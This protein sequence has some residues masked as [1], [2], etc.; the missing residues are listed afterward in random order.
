MKQKGSKNN[1]FSFLNIDKAE[2]YFQK[3]LVSILK[4]FIKSW[5]EFGKI[6]SK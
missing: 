6:Y 1:E 2:T 3:I 5:R 4:R